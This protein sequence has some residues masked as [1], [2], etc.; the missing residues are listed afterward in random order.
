M[1]IRGQRDTEAQVLLSFVDEIL[2]VMPHL[3]LRYKMVTE[4]ALTAH[5]A[6]YLI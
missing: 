4:S 2:H 5:P 6:R 3:R 1:F